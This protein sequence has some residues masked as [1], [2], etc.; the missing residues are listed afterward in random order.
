MPASDTGKYTDDSY[1][2]PP[3]PE[4]EETESEP[5]EG[6][7]GTISDGPTEGPGIYIAPGVEIGPQ[8][9][10]LLPANGANAK[11]RPIVVRPED[12]FLVWGVVTYVIKKL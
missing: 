9:I 7:T 6:S 8:G 10:R 1:W 11:Y 2:V 12:E 4:E 3:E 5:D